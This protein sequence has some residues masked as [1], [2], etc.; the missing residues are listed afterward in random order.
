MSQNSSPT[1]EFNLNS[2]LDIQSGITKVGDKETYFT[3]LEGFEEVLNANIS[4]MNKSY[5]KQD[6]QAFREQAFVLMA[7]SAYIAAGKVYHI[8]S[9]I[10][11]AFMRKEYK[12]E[13]SYY[14][15]LIEESIAFKAEMKKALADKK[16]KLVTEAPS[17]ARKIT[18]P[19][20]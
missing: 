12:E 6:H 9:K 7:T 17:T 10:H 20:R 2:T 3:M 13:L 1:K 5:E 16:G 14:P 18:R 15:Q 8:A 4:A 11:G 19:L